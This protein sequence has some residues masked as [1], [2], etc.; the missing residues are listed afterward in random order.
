MNLVAFLAARAVVAGLLVVFFSLVGEVVQ[1]KRFAGIFSAA[2]SV[3]IANLA[4]IV[5]VQGTAKA[6]VESRAMVGGAVAMTVACVA[7]IV[8]VRRLRAVKGAGVIALVW[9]AVAGAA[10]GVLV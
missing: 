2:P 10:A 5:V 8:A 3:A 7:G 6:A 1:P 4:L 9:L